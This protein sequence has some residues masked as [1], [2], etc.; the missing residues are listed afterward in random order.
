[1]HLATADKHYER[2]A[3]A[4]AATATYPE[5]ELNGL[6]P[7]RARLFERSGDGR[8]RVP[9]SVAQLVSFKPLNLMAPWPMKGPFDAIFCRNVT[10]YFDR[11]TQSTMFRRFG[12]ILTPA[13]MLYVGHSENMRSTET[14]LRIVGKTVYQRSTQERARSAA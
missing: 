2:M 12:D 5:G 1:M 13:G 6:S 9:Q 8:I 14:G 11:T 3:Y 4:K 10:I 7:E